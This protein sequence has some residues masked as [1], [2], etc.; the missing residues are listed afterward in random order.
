VKVNAPHANK[1]PEAEFEVHCTDLTCTFS[2][3]S[4]D[5][6]GNIASWHWDFGDG[7]SSNDQN[8]S[9]SY[10]A[11][12]PYPVTLTV[13]DN[14]GATGSKTH[15]ANP[16]APPNESPTAEFTW[17]CT[18]LDCTFTDGS[19]DSDG[20]IAGWSWD[21]D[22]GTGSTSQSPSH[23]YAAGGTYQ[24]K[25]T[26]IDNN[27]AGA[28]V[29]H[30]VTVTPP[31]PPNQAP[32]AVPDTYSTPQDAALTVAAPGVLTNDTDP[33][34]D[35]LTAQLVGSTANGTVSLQSDGSF[36]YTPNAGFTGDDSFSYTAS[37]GSLTSTATVTITVN[38]P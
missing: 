35:A 21:F 29:Q 5:D 34:G 25:L 28:T 2:D 24:V 6:D 27:G 4:K 19:S 7:Q 23:S 36:T 38:T 3:K 20:T 9:H 15:D 33:D 1:A 32:S 11:A 22:D 10:G 13:T 18:G 14:E 12:G 17:G 8:P 16:T 37:D 26:V 31:P 30:D